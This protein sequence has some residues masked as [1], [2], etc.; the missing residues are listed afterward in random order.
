MTHPQLA[1]RRA[2]AAIESGTSVNAIDFPSAEDEVGVLKTSCV[3][4]GF[5]DA[6]ENKVVDPD[7]IERASCPVR[8]D[9][10]IVSRMNTPALVGAAGH[11]QRDYDN[12]YLPDRLWQVRTSEAAVARFVYWWMQTRE[13]RDQVAAICVGTSSSMQNLSQN[14]FRSFQMPY[15]SHAIQSAISDFLDRETAQ[16]DELIGKQERLI[17]LLAEKRQAI[18]THAVTKG[19]DPTAPTKPSGI[20][21]LGHIP[22]TWWTTELKRAL[23]FITSGSRGWAEFYADHGTPFVRIGNLTRGH[24]HLD[25]SETQHVDIPRDSE[26]TRAVVEAGDVLFSITA[27][28]GS[29]GVASEKEAGSYVSQHVALTRLDQNRLQSR[30]LAYFVLSEFGQRQLNQGA[31]GGTKLQL[32]LEDIKRL[33][34]PVPET[35]KQIEITRYLDESTTRIDDLLELA[36]RSISLLRE[37][38]SALISAAVTGVI[39]V[40]TKGTK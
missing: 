14:D 15:P 6:T 34:I 40:Q 13:Y 28:L 12:L 38:R 24:L 29:V 10:L 11:T 3:S 26:G 23:T 25:M 27:Y 36:R 35:S 17:E 4:N 20:P 9:R 7:E 33:W 32:S 21:W 16:I 30:F 8:S 37:R 2:V 1:V 5:F 22:E 39:D 31:Y 18:I 19:L